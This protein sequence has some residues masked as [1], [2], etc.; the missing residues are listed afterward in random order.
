MSVRYAVAAMITT[1]MTAASPLCCS[2]ADAA[3]TVAVSQEGANVVANGSGTIDPSDLTFAIDAYFNPALSPALGAVATG[4]A[5][6]TRSELFRGVIG[7]SQFGDGDSVVPSSSS[8]PLVG[9][10]IAQSFL[11]LPFDYSAGTQLTDSS[12]YANTTIS[13]LGLTAGTYVYHLG[14]GA[15]ADTF[16]IDIESLPSSVIPEPTSLALLAVPLGLLG[17]AAARSSGSVRGP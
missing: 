11:I 13:D 14:S 12:T 17:L 4:L 8:G 9:V 15:D 6:S 10:A 7:P 2:Y 16:I 1:A 5:T 3:Y